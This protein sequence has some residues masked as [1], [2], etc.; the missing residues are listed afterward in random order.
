LK[1]ARALLVLLATA[2]LAVTVIRNAAVGA[3]AERSPDEAA[4]L[5]PMH[6][7]AELSYGMTE[8][9]R[10]ARLRKPVPPAVFAT[11]ND[12]A[13]KAPLAPEPFLVRGVQAQ[14]AGNAPLAIDAFAA[15]AKRDPRSLPAHYFLADTLFRS[16]DTARAL[17]EIG[18]LARL[19]PGG[20]ASLAPYLATYAK[21]P[22]TW[23]Q[24]RK[25]FRSTPD[26]EDAALTA[27][28]A[29]PANVGTVMAL[30]DEQH[31]GKNAIWLPTLVNSLV[32]AGEYTKAHEVWASIS[33]AR[34]APGALLY[35]PRFV[36]PS[37][38]TPF[39]W[40]LTSSPVGLAERRPGGGLHVI[41]YGR[42]DG[43]LARQLLVLSP[44]R[45]RMA[46]SVEGNGDAEGLTWS[47]RCDKSDTP[48]VAVPLG[49]AASRPLSFAVAAGCPAQWIELSGVSS[50]VSHQSDVTIK[51]VDLVAEQPNG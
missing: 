51:S 38:P 29:D 10:A 34:P 35:D 9:G 36:E 33:N 2:V 4:R 44:G 19:A 24:L 13:L 50:D 49:A 18:I 45:Y 1:I 15:A 3:L 39:N 31:R 5:W 12:A 32:A 17:Q 21:D 25:L 22:K 23:P 20:V 46:I 11:I 43:P 47:V 6:P 40:V 41:F 16:G 28:A 48:L 37:A 14:L 26:V 27:I 7:A 30:A 42:E 8:I